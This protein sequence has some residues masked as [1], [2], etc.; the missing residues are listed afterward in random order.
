M[1]IYACYNLPSS[2]DPQ[3]CE[4][5]NLIS[6]RSSQSVSQSRMIEGSSFNRQNRACTLIMRQ[7]F[8]PKQINNTIFRRLSKFQ[9]SVFQDKW[10][11]R[12]LEYMRERET[13]D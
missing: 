5:L 7:V 12:V 1:N 8:H 2:S 10:E 11:D 3:S 4:N 6:G 13:G 9:R